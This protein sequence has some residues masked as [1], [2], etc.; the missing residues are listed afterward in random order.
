MGA[1]W[2]KA[3]IICLLFEAKWGLSRKDA[4]NAKVASNC[5]GRHKARHLQA[6]ASSQGIP[7]RFWE[8]A[9]MRRFYAP[10]AQFYPQAIFVMDRLYHVGNEPQSYYGAI[11]CFHGFPLCQ[12]QDSTQENLPLEGLRA[13]RGAP[14]TSPQPLQ[15]QRV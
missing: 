12:C 8:D 2:E 15:W 10:L 7:N 14:L 3:D 9:R 5:K 4:K 6:K 1:W 11:A 13:V